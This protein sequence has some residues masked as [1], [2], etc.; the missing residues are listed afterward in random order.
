MKNSYQ[1]APER[2]S[3]SSNFGNEP[4]FITPEL[5]LGQDELV[6]RPVANSAE[7]R[8]VYRLV[9]DCYVSRGYAT[10]QGNGLFDPYPGFDRLAETTVLVAVNAGQIVGT[11]SMTLDGPSGLTVEEDFP[12]ECEQLRKRS[13]FMAAAWRLAIR[14][15]HRSDRHVL[16]ALIKEMF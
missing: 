8:M 12:R 15:S 2:Q 9:H 13:R 11:F 7:L 1:P 5:L 6:I 16:I 14:P 4:N 3:D 10:P